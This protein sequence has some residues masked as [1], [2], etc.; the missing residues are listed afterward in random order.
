MKKNI[1][2]C[3]LFFIFMNFISCNKD[4]QFHKNRDKFIAHAGG[5]IKGY[6]R[7]NSLESLDASYKKGFRMFELDLQMTN[8]GKIVAVHDPINMTEAQFLAQQIKGEFTPMNMEIINHWFEN[9][10]DAIF[11][12]DKINNPKLL[13]EQFKFKDRL[14]MELFTWEAIYEAIEL[15][16]IPMVSPIVFW[17]T[18]NI[19]EKLESLNIKYIGMHQEDINRDKELLKKLKE[20]GFKTYV[21]FTS[22]KIDGMKSEKYIWKYNMEYCY[23]MYANE[24][25]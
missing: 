18:P 3:L 16:I 14:I 5:K 20:K 9:H 11:V 13:A 17:N 21:W 15:N 6:I 25:I 22:R 12:T 1:A 19:E 23:G 4:E 8:D 24:I 7:T 10:P 2:I